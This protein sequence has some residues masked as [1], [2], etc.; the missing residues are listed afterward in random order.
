MQSLGQNS[1]TEV[2]SNSLIKPVDL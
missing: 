2:A 1:N